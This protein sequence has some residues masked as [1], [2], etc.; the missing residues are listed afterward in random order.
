MKDLAKML[1]INTMALNAYQSEKNMI[2]RSLQKIDDFKK[3]IKYYEQ[4]L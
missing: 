3:D 2:T 1:G 4:E